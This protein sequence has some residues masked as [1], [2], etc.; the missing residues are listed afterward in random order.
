MINLAERLRDEYY[1]MKM[2][3]RPKPVRR[4]KV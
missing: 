4:A 1:L 2:I 3:P